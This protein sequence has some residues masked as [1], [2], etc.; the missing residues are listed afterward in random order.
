MKN[1]VNVVKEQ[2]MSSLGSMFTKE[3]VIKVI[4][5][6]EITEPSAINFDKDWFDDMESLIESIESDVDD[7]SVDE[8]EVEFGLDGNRIY[9]ENV[10][11]DKSSIESTI[12][13]LKEKLQEL[14]SLSVS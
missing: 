10:D 2:V 5:S 13:D 12:R 1:S 11:I 6:I 7:I 8:D 4:D 3:D 9:V 14:K